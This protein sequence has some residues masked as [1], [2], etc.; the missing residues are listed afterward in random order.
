MATA[1]SLAL[2]L[3][4]P[5]YGMTTFAAVARV[6]GADCLAVHPAGRDEYGAQRFEAGAP[7]GEPQLVPGEELR[8]IRRVAGEG[9]G[10]LGGAEVG[11][12]ERVLA[13][14]GAVAERFAAGERPAGLEAFYLREPNV[15]RPRRTPLVAANDGRGGR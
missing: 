13:L 1:E 10:A 15:T 6:A 14:L 7:V 9:G 11:R 4:I 3:G 2:G 5:V 12:Q 8:G